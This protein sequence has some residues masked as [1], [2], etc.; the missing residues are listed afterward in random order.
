M[1]ANIPVGEDPFDLSVAGGSVWVGL[2]K[3]P[4]VVRINAATNTVLSKLTVSATM[5]AIAATDH[6]V[7]AL[8]N[9]PI[10]EGGT[11]PP[12]GEVTRIGY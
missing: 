6:A 10:P 7:W 1:V 9:L 4:T 12:P 11:A 8:H 5:Y 2:Y 3:S